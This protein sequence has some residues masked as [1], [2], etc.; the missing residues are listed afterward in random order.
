MIFTVLSSLLSPLE[1]FARA[2]GGGSGGSSG[3]GGEGIFIILGYL[4]MHFV[5]AALRKRMPAQN[6]VS[7]VA[8]VIGWVIAMVYAVFWSFFWQGIGVFIGL[9][10]FVGI[11]AGLYNW[12]AKLKQSKQTKAQLTAA[13][14]RDG[15]WDESRLVEFAKAAFV[16]YQADWSKLD[17]A[18][19]QVYLTP[20]YAYHAALLMAI[21][22][23]MGR[24]NLMED[25]RIVDAQI[26]DIHDA[27]DNTQDR[28]TAGVTAAAQDRLVRASDGSVIFADSNTFTEY[29]HFVRNGEGWLLDG[30]TQQTADPGSENMQMRSFAEQQG[31]YYSEDMG[32]LFIPERGQLFDGAKFGTSDINNHIVGLYN[33]QLLVQLY[34]YVKNPQANP[35][36]NVIAQLNVPKQYGN[37]VVR[38]KKAFQMGIRGLERVET[39]WTQFNK[40]YEVFATNYELATSFELLDPTYMEQLESLPFEVAIEVVDNVIYLYA[41][42]MLTSIEIYATMLDL[43]QKAFKEMRL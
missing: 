34:S 15:A 2:G 14:D 25:V 42:E 18:A 10:A 20:R 28:F 7:A 36:S 41:D 43:A 29:W 24:R 23:S 4:P 1:Q 19:M 17:A 32:W 6:G 3:G 16:R 8:Q 12:F 37:I 27:E 21:L 5:G 26:I 9:A 11:A 39:E 13:A 33:N 30:I 31:Y 40:K 38:R 22:S 35:K